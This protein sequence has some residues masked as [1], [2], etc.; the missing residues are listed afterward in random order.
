MNGTYMLSQLSYYVK[1]EVFMEKIENMDPTLSFFQIEGGQ[2]L[3]H[4]SSLMPKP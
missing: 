2:H 1:L 3:I 4:P